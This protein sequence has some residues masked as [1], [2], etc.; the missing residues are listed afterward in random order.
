MRGIDGKIEGKCCPISAIIEHQNRVCFSHTLLEF[1]VTAFDVLLWSFADE[2]QDC[3][4]Y[5]CGDR[6]CAWVCEWNSS[7]LIEFNLRKQ[8]YLPKHEQTVYVMNNLIKTVC[9][10]D[11]EGWLVY[12]L[13]VNRDGDFPELKLI[14]M[15][16]NKLGV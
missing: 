15:S 12:M 14:S 5:V 3:E 8:E 2:N 4:V 1:S 13:D 7:D 6:I 16:D 10:G 9:L 11:H